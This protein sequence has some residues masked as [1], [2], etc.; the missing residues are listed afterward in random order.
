MRFYFLFIVETKHLRKSLKQSNFTEISGIFAYVYISENTLLCYL[1]ALWCSNNH[2]L[3]SKQDALKIVKLRMCPRN[4]A[5]E[6][7]EYDPFQTFRGKEH[8]T[9]RQCKYI[10][11][12]IPFLGIE[13]HYLHN[14]RDY[15]VTSLAC[16]TSFV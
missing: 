6:S 3:R 9:I 8:L 11:N 5:S 7:L 12:L 4:L 13:P 10:E 2:L 14:R 15:L 16:H 1:F